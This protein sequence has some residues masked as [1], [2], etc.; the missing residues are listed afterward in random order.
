MQEGQIEV[1]S[2]TAAIDNFLEVDF[3][4]VKS[5]VLSLYDTLQLL[6]IEYEKL[7]K[8]VTDARKVHRKSVL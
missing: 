6:H 4:E 2:R 7:L 5:N 3:D 8:Q 1:D